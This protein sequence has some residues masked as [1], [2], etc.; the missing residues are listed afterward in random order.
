MCTTLGWT[1]QNS[2]TYD[3]FKAMGTAQVHALGKS[4][5]VLYDLKYMLPAE[6][7]D[8]RL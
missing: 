6:A 8:L 4:S 3:A 2:F 5:H 7:A 1:S